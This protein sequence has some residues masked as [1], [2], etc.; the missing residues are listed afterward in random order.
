[1]IPSLAATSSG[2]LPPIDEEGAPS[3]VSIDATRGVGI[4]RHPDA[5]TPSH[6]YTGLTDA[7]E[8]QSFDAFCR[9]DAFLLAQAEL[10]QA[11][12]ELTEW[13]VRR[14]EPGLARLAQWRR[15]LV[16]APPDRRD[17]PE[18]G[19]LFGFG[20]RWLED[21]L[22]ALRHPGLDVSTKARCLDRLFPDVASRESASAC[23]TRALTYLHYA[24]L[25]PPERA[26][27]E[28][29]GELQSTAVYAFMRQLHSHDRAPAAIRHRH[30]VTDADQML[31]LLGVIQSDDPAR[32]PASFDS[33]PETVNRCESAMRAAASPAAVAAALARGALVEAKARLNQA[34]QG[35]TWQTYDGQR[36][37]DVEALEAALAPLRARLGPLSALDVVATRSPSAGRR[38][39]DDSNRLA[40]RILE[41]M[42]EGGMVAPP[43]PQRIGA[44]GNA[45][46]RLSLYHVGEQIVFVQEDGAPRPGMRHA[47]Q[48]DDL[49]HL[50]RPAGFDEAHRPDSSMSSRWRP[51]LAEAALRNEP[52]DSDR[53]L[54]TGW[55]EW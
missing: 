5:L 42:A 38:L 47:V 51:L 35:L 18:R 19:Y 6:S 12:A 20:K 1:M 48:I 15:D 25:G 44:C 36:K 2:A 4:A 34:P 7:G 10:R 21:L 16:D 41:H 54:P 39:L 13:A 29:R 53:R 46:Q 49:A 31:Q 26:A 11:W 37:G 30:T 43:Q 28:V 27:S 50:D 33:S 3:S 45:H 17:T 52:E 24:H 8:H 22:A 55:T 23:F 40:M 9:S 14:H 32:L